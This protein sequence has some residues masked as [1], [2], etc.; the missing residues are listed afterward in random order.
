MTFLAAWAACGL[1]YVLGYVHGR[2]FARRDR[3]P[4]SWLS[5]N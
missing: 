1:V 5:R 4:G 2:A 3:R